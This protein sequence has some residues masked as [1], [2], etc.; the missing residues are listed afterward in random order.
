[1]FMSETYFGVEEDPLDEV[2]SQGA[3]NDLGHHSLRR[4]DDNLRQREGRADEMRSVDG[5]GASARG[6]RV[7][8]NVPT[9]LHLLVS[10]TAAAPVT[11]PRSLHC[12]PSDLSASFLIKRESELI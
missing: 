9:P 2:E 10:T 5:N 12:A 8:C 1:M 7:E 6:G 4:R 3:E 11:C